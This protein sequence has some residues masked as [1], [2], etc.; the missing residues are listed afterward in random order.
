MDL[1][2][3]IPPRDQDFFEVFA[4][5]FEVFLSF[6]EFSGVFGPASMHSDLFGPVRTRS[7]VV[8]CLGTQTR[9]G[10]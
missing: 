9:L 3:L 2:L 6:L 4:N 7:D 1:G 10:Y 5:L 8:R